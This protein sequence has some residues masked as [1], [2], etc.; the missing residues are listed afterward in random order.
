MI[1]NGKGLKKIYTMGDAK[2][3]ALNGIDITFKEN[4]FY[5]ITGKSGSG[6]S[7]LLHILSGMDKPTKGQVIFQDKNIGELNDKELSA[8]KRKKFGFIFQAYNLLPELCAL[9]NILLPAYLD[10]TTIDKEHFK[11]IVSALHLTK[12]VK[13]YPVQLSGGEQQRVAIA[14]AL[15][16]KPQIVFADEPTGNLDQHNSNEVVKL[17]AKTQM[18]FQQT[19]IMVT[20]DIDAA[21]KADQIV[22][23]QD[24]RIT[25]KVERYV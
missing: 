20:H 6:K 19:I 4:T 15:I 16:N 23:I 10:D 24:G 1:L 9:E 3:I 12:L 14:R 21:K 11:K 7:T 8:V 2:T 5:A 22:H 13:K 25:D 17:L 18:E